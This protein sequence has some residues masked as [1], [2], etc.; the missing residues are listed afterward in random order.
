VISY[1]RQQ[2]GGYWRGTF[3]AMASPCEV[4]V[5]TD[6]ERLARELCEKV[7]AEALRIESKYSRYRD[8]SELSRINC[9]DGQPVTVDDETAHLLDYADQCYRLSEGRFDISSGVLREAWRFDGSD[10][11]PEAAVV[12]KLLARIG[13]HKVEWHAPVIVLPPEM[14]LDFGGIGKEYAVDRCAL[15]CARHSEAAVLINFG[16]DLHVSAPRRGNQPWYVAVDDPRLESEQGMATIEL[17]R[18][19]IATSGDA[20]RYLVK[21]GV[22]YSHIL[23]PQSGWPVRGAPRSVTV[24]AQSCVEAGMLATFAMLQ[25]ESAEQFLREQ[26]AVYWCVW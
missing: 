23:D 17:R 12:E 9:S 7:Q 25:G 4:L 3:D 18:G 10:R 6:D 11:L 13:W 8:D 5:D 20:H 21:G 24:L 1:Q 22:R 15:L 2:Q 19:A 14:E 26:Q 16:G